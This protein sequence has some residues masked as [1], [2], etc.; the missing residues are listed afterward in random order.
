MNIQTER[1]LALCDAKNI[2]IG[3]L[4]SDCGFW[5]GYIK[6]V[7]NGY[8]AENLM[9]I[10]DYLSTTIDYLLGKTDNPEIPSGDILAKVALDDELMKAIR[11]LQKLNP[12]DKELI[13]GMINSLYEKMEG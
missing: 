13:I 12:A 6:Q 4:E 10:A 8:D 3:R 1:I 2:K 11:N 7:K 9:I 5:N